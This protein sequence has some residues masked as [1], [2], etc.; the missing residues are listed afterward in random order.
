MAPSVPSCDLSDLKA[1]FK[2]EGYI[3]AKKMV[4]SVGEELG[5]FSKKTLD[6]VVESDGFSRFFQ[7][8]VEDLP[9]GLF[10]FILTLCGLGTIFLLICYKSR[11]QARMAVAAVDVLI[12][13]VVR[14]TLGIFYLFF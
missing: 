14:N 6:S 8:V 3:L 4:K 9:V 11:Q 13:M 2:K 7:A 10:C 1:Y 5:D 12:D